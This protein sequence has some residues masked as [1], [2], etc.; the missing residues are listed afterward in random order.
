MRTAFRDP[1]AWLR[2]GAV[3]LILLVPVTAL[4]AHSGSYSWSGLDPNLIAVGPGGGGVSFN[5]TGVHLETSTAQ[6]VSTVTIATLAYAANISLDMSFTPGSSAGSNLLVGFSSPYN[7]SSVLLILDGR[8]NRGTVVMIDAEGLVDN[9][10]P[11]GGFDPAQSFRV[12]T[13][14]QPP[15]AV[16]IQFIQG[17]FAAEAQVDF[18]SLVGTVPVNLLAEVTTEVGSAAA[19]ITSVEIMIPANTTPVYSAT[20]TVLYAEYGLIFVLSLLGYRAEI[21]G[22]LRR[23]W[24]SIRG[25]STVWQRTPSVIRGAC[26]I[27]L[28]AL[29]VQL[30][31][32]TTGSQPYDLFTQELWSY[33]GSHTGVV[34][35]YAISQ[36]VPGGKG[37]ASTSYIGSGYPYPPLSIYL[38]LAAGGISRLVPGSYPL[39]SQTVGYLLKGFWL[40]FLDATAF[41]VAWELHRSHVNPRWTWAAFAFVA[42]NPALLLGS[43]VWGSFD[44]VLAILLLLFAISLRRAAWGWACFFLFLAVLTKQDALLFLPLALPILVFRAGLIPTL[45]AG[46]KGL[47]AAFFVLLPLLSAGLSPAFVVNASV[48]SNV[49]NVAAT[50]PQNIPPWQLVVSNGDYGIWPL[51]TW[52]QQ[53]QHG[54]ARLQFSDSLP[55][56]AFGLPYVDVGLVLA[57]IGIVVLWW[58]L[59]RR[60]NAA[61]F[62]LEWP[63]LLLVSFLWSFE[64]LTRLSPRYLTLT[65]PLSM[66]LWIPPASRRWG[67]G[68]TTAITVVSAL[69]M[70][71]VLSLTAVQVPATGLG[72]LRS[73]VGFFTSDTFI[74][75]MS[76]GQI[77][78]VLSAVA[79]LGSVAAAKG[80]PGAPRPIPPRMSMTPLGVSPRV[81]VVVLNY[82]GGGLGR[83][84]VDSVL[85]STYPNLEVLVVDNA[86]KDD[87]LER[88]A[89]LER[90]G[91]IRIVR[92]AS[93]VGY[94]PGNNVGASEATG[95][96]VL[97]LNNDTRIDPA[98]IA[99]MVAHFRS[100]PDTGAAQPLM[101]SMED[102]NRISNAGNDLDTLGFHECLGEGQPVGSVEVRPLTSYAQGAA[103]M[104]RRPLFATV[105]GFDPLLRFYHTDADL[106]WKVWL[107]GYEV[108]VVASSRVL[109]AEGT[110]ASAASL[111][112]RLLRMVHGQLVMVGKNYD[113]TDAVVA[114]VSLAT[115]DVGTAT[116]LFVLGRRE[117]AKMVLRGV[118]AFLLE[119]RKVMSA[120]RGIARFRAV[121]DEEIRHRALRPFNPLGVFALKRR[122]YGY[123][124]DWTQSRF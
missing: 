49:L 96:L 22:S 41:T 48:G 85:A 17:A 78:L 43:V 26:V 123:S 117:E 88:M 20:S 66:V 2:I 111:A 31:L 93:N 119:L 7:A 54:V 99:G 76:I 114:M 118:G 70:A 47:V 73:A 80:F 60:K 84:C 105:G 109:H 100:H 122:G 101:I 11:L 45:R 34:S 56:Q 69:S 53:R 92:N 72:V 82:N 32:M 29:P 35:V 21:A 74:T 67:V 89:D 104:I 40:L 10:Y 14:F 124:G 23:L 65:I 8:T 116:L 103:F 25:L 33:L 91:R 28:V 75:G 94:G 113:T 24:S 57:A 107:A 42:L 59:W 68:F 27:A 81:T 98:A 15:Q 102:E 13:S 110:S 62:P 55:N 39:P 64:V 36:V 120:R 12:L 90:S 108:A 71:S 106:S 52:V 3:V 95:E 30:A 58:V 121:S 38:F 61:D 6:P 1:K 4:T 86:S 112:D 50:A 79:A 63:L 16:S 77:L 97:F 44:V 9:A 83:A 37:S 46:A 18:P 19:E 87:S 115:I 51:V 5:A